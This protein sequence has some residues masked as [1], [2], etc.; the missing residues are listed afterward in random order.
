MK[1]YSI[2]IY[3]N[4][5]IKINLSKSIL[6]IFSTKLLYIFNETNF[7]LWLFCIDSC[8]TLSLIMNENILSTEGDIIAADFH[9]S[10]APF[11]H[12]FLAR[13]KPELEG[14]LLCQVVL[15]SAHELLAN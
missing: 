1:R 4:S 14:R 12:C 10:Q 7:N 15:A 11:R 2:Q 5:G 6:A 8:N 13:V 9:L 3:V